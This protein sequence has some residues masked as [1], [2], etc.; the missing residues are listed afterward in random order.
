MK[1]NKGSGIIFMVL[2]AIFLMH[3]SHPDAFDFLLGVSFISSGV[4]TYIGMPNELPKTKGFYR[5]LALFAISIFFL[6]YAAGYI[7][8]L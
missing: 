7:Y 8:L 3:Y 4:N 6:G 2:G 1:S 5:W